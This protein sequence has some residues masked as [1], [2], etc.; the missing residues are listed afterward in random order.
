MV[1]DN[2]I[3]IFLF[4][5]STVGH[6]TSSPLAQPQTA[7]IP[8]AAK[9]QGLIGTAGIFNLSPADHLGLGAEAFRLVEIRG[10]NW[11]I[12]N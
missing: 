8:A 9:N 3:I 11:H 1:Q 10:G 2:L 12:V 4:G 6:T 5:R 7:S